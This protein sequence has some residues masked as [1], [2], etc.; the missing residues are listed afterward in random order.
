MRIISEEFGVFIE[1]NSVWEFVKF[2]IG[3]LLGVIVFFGLILLVIYICSL[4]K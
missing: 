4:F 2:K 1:F 3:R